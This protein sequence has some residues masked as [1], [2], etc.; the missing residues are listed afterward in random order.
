[1]PKIVKQLKLKLS[2]IGQK[3]HFLIDDFLCDF[4]LLLQTQAWCDGKAYL[5]YGKG[6]SLRYIPLDTLTPPLAT[7]TASK[8]KNK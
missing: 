3:H 8:I 2:V 1:M 5:H 7:M 6:S 4:Q